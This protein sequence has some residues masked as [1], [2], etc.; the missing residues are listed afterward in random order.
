M[1][2]LSSR[3]ILEKLISFATVSRDSNLQLITFV[4]DYLASHG[5]ESELFHNDEGTK[6]SLFATIGPKDR[7][8]VV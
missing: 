6:A 1:S 7:G 2:N 3:D 8:G 4:R 5:V